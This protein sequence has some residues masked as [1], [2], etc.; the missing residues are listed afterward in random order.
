[1]LCNKVSHTIITIFVLLQWTIALK[2]GVK[3]S[4]SD[5]TNAVENCPL[6][7]LSCLLFGM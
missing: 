3:I 2:K 1:M 4:S 5:V 6:S 7:R